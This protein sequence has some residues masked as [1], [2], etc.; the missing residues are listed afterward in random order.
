MLK[1]N[2]ENRRYKK[3]YIP[4]LKKVMQRKKFECFKALQMYQVKRIHYTLAVD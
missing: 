1:E 3:W 4:L 2:V